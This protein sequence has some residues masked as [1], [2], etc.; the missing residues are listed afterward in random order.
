[1]WYV[2]NKWSAL[3]RTKVVRKNTSSN[4]QVSVLI[5]GPAFNGIGRMCQS[6]GSNQN[7]HPPVVVRKP[8][9]NQF[10]HYHISS[11]GAMLFMVNNVTWTE[12]SNRKQ[13]KVNGAT[14][15]SFLSSI[16][17]RYLPWLSLLDYESP[18]LSASWH[19]DM[20]KLAALLALSKIISPV[21]GRFLSPRAS[22]YHLEP[23]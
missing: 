23:R 10:I 11:R 22:I 5:P 16:N 6:H 15:C 21:S 4:P 8:L 2:Y 12:C 20:A 14:N 3:A 13:V 7:F 17:F 1:M 19:H 9:C 18:Y